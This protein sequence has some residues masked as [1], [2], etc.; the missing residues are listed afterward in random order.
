MLLTRGGLAI[1]NHHNTL[2]V[3]GYSATTGFYTT[4]R[5]VAEA[6]MYTYVLN[7]DDDFNSA[8]CLAMSRLSV[9]VCL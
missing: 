3:Y 2:C 9:C 1:V 7:V 8:Q 6:E 5:L 4:L